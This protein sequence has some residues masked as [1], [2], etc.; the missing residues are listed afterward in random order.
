MVHRVLLMKDG[1]IQN[2][3]ENDTRIPAAELE[4]L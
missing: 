1:Q 4:D 2:T 3:Y